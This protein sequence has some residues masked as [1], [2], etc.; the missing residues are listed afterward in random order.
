MLLT[1]IKNSICRGDTNI[2]LWIGRSYYGGQRL[3]AVVDGSTSPR[4]GGMAGG[5]SSLWVSGLEEQHNTIYI[6]ILILD[7]TTVVI[8][9]TSS[10][11]Y[12]SGI[13]RYRYATIKFNEEI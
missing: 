6:L 11:D 1:E 12:D 4:D 10:I 7:E 5:V 9:L 3:G 2:V 13:V 8:V